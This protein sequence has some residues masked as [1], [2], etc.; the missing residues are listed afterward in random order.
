MGQVVRRVHATLVTT[1][2]DEVV[3]LQ[4]GVATNRGGVLAQLHTRESASGGIQ[5]LPRR[6]NHML[7]PQGL[8]LGIHP[9]VLANFGDPEHRGLG[10]NRQL[11]ERGDG[12]QV[13]GVL[14]PRGMF[15]FQAERRRDPNGH[16]I[17]SNIP[18][19][20]VGKDGVMNRV[21]S[22][23]NAN[24]APT[25]APRSCRC[26]RLSVRPTHQ[27]PRHPPLP[28]S[29]RTHWF[30]SKKSCAGFSLVQVGSVP[31]WEVGLR[32]STSAQDQQT[33]HHP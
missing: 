32:K 28:R 25:R 16:R 14:L 17:R 29:R 5:E 23:H 6:P 13:E 4:F 19:E 11:A 27:C 12:V 7:G 33:F 3:P 18:M 9:E 2:N 26:Q 15:D 20:F 10:L 8:L 1:D 22:G 30:P 21:S 24:A 31:N